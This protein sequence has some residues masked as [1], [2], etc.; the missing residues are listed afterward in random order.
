[1]KRFT[2]CLFATLSGLAF[3]AAAPYSSAA[4]GQGI[5]IPAELETAQTAEVIEAEADVVGPVE[6]LEPAGALE[7][8]EPTEPAAADAETEADT[9]I[10]TPEDKK[11]ASPRLTEAERIRR[12]ILIQGDSA[13]EAGNFAAAEALYR[14]HPGPRL[15]GR[16]LR[17]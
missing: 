15:N 10:E 3:C 16:H 4:F 9:E 5:A 12:K 17:L 14:R 8:L 7:P 6:L 2:P 1:M 11:A 13:Y